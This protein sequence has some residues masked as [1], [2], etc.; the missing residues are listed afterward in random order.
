MNMDSHKFS[1]VREILDEVCVRK[2]ILIN[3]LCLQMAIDLQVRF[4]AVA[5]VWEKCI[6]MFCLS[7][8]GTKRSQGFRSKKMKY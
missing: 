3:L 2:S 7:L 5:M 1:S 6:R 8:N 4:T